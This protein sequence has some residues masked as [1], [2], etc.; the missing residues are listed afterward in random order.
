[1]KE[2][3]W[4]YR[5][6]LTIKLYSSV[7]LSGSVCMYTIFVPALKKNYHHIISIPHIKMYHLPK[8][9]MELQSSLRNWYNFLFLKSKAKIKQENKC[10]GWNRKCHLNSF[11][12]L[13]DWHTTQ[14]SERF[15]VD[16]V[17]QHCFNSIQSWTH[18]VVKILM[19]KEARESQRGGLKGKAHSDP[20][21]GFGT[22]LSR[23]LDAISRI[24]QQVYFWLRM[25]I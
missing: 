8:T 17:W 2:E 14:S 18:W 9:R 16:C 15:G 20:M 1:M 3:L 22:Q 7:A 12:V 5:S 11:Q 24:Q 23:P 6:T 21:A 25:P 19:G 4:H 13:L 10:V